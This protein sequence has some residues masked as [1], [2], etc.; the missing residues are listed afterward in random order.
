MNN[1]DGVRI[2]NLD[3]A[4]WRRFRAIAVQDGVTVGQLLTQVLREWIERH[5]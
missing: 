3:R 2:R 4:V 5:G 1:D